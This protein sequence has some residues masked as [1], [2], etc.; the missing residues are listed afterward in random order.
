[1]KKSA[2]V[3]LYFSMDCGMLVGTIDVSPAFLEHGSAEK[4]RGLST[5]KL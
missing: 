3:L 5:C 1:M 4:N 2:E